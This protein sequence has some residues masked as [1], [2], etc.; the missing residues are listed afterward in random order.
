MWSS[1]QRVNSLMSYVNDDYLCNIK[2]ESIFIVLN[3]HQISKDEVTKEVVM[4]EGTLTLITIESPFS[5]DRIDIM[6]FLKEKH[7]LQLVRWFTVLRTVCFF[8]IFPPNKTSCVSLILI[9]ESV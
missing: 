7:K 9:M 4:S 3:R 1:V 6:V 2:V 8:T 5:V